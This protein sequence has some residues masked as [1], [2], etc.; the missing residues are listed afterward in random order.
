MQVYFVMQVQ[1]IL[2]L[3]IWTMPINTFNLRIMNFVINHFHIE[4]G[5]IG[6]FISNVK[7]N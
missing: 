3:V 1:Y 4:I 5:N 6:N 7:K 2:S